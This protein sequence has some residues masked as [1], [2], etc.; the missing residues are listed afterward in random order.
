VVTFAQLRDANP[1]MFHQSAAAWK[2][3]ADAALEHAGYLDDRVGT[4]IAKPHWDGL[5][6][7][8]ARGKVA[9]TQM[10]LSISAEQLK[11]VE[12]VL[13]TAGQDFEED[14]NDLLTTVAEAK[15]AGFNVDGEGVVT[16]PENLTKG[17]PATDVNT[18]ND[19]ASACQVRINAAVYRA[20]RV[21]KG[22]TKELDELMP[23]NGGKGG[24]GGGG[25]GGGKNGGGGGGGGGGEHRG[26]GPSGG[27][28]MQ[29]PSGKVADWINQAI[30]VLRENGINLGPNDASYIATIIQYE[31]GGNPNSI[32]LWDSNY[33]AGH[34]SK[35]LMQTIDGTFNA[36]ALPGHTNVWNPVDN[37]VAGTRYALER[38]HS[39]AN[40]PGIRN[41]LNGG[42]YVGY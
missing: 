30:Q 1:A 15:Q 21:D 27:P 9:H 33:D 29:R 31:S 36:H 13:I 26:Y 41:L 6:S 20:T 42:K 7:E 16:V 28:P 38:Y 39:L 22:V 40:V 18:I 11:A 37:I 14:Q 24:S 17:K 4:H 35:G 10:N 12:T 19:H 2:D 34:P 23:K 5:T 32:N 3:W 25:G 8:L